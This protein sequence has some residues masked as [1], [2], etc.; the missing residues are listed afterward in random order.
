MTTSH[1]QKPLTEMHFGSESPVN[2]PN[3]NDMISNIAERH[4]VDA[5]AVDVHGVDTLNVDA[6][7][8]HRSIERELEDEFVKIFKL[9]SD[10]TRFKTL[11]FLMREGELHVTA[12]CKRLSQSQPAVSHHLALLR[13]AGLIGVR[14][15]GKHNYYSVTKSRF[16]QI[17]ENL[18]SVFTN[19][20]SPEFRFGSFVV[21][22]GACEN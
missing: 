5:P 9:L 15:D 4:G 10:E 21:A 19:A 8:S 3:E 14:R 7:N 16:H 11:L 20:Q 12:L 22:Q 17:F 1:P 13:S 18:F 6:H 2:D